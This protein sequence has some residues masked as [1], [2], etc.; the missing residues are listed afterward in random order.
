MAAFDKEW[1]AMPVG[2]RPGGVAEFVERVNPALQ[3]RFSF[4][5][6]GRDDGRARK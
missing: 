2:Q 3:K 6:V 4:G 1:H 5:E